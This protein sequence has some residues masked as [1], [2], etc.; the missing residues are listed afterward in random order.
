M[1]LAYTIAHYFSPRYS[2]NHKAKLI[3]SKSLVFIALLLIVYQLLLQ[4]IPSSGLKILG[5]AANIP[6][7]KI[8]ELTNQ[9][10]A[11]AGIPALSYN[12]KLAEAARKKG[13][14]MLQYDYWAHV[15]PD[16]TEPWDFFI[17]EGYKYRYAGENLAR[18][19][20]NPSDVIEAWMASPSHRENILSEKYT[21]I[22]VAVVEGSIG[23]VDTTIIVQF[24][25]SLLA[26]G[27][28]KI[29]VAQAKPQAQ[30]QT[31]PPATVTPQITGEIL[32]T[33][34]T[35][36]LVAFISPKFPENSITSE[37]TTNSFQVLI[38]PFESTRKIAFAV[39]I[40]LFLVFI[41]DAIIVSRR[42]IPR[43]GGKVFAHM[44][45]LGMVLAILIL[46]KAGKI[47]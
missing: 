30:P 43:L 17:N 37:Q 12:S 21:E 23:G 9:K 40:L 28:Q 4:L 45:F 3:H 42:R 14:H 26:E 32:V 35:P 15:A 22:G 34:P 19:F 6:P 31:I 18:D 2:N 13:E 1:D 16:G 5:Y 20:S 36:A 25:G 46:A 39:T 44:A 11:E 47:L 27:T 33:T 38:S 10:R 29:P 24:F 7:E 41:A 8:I